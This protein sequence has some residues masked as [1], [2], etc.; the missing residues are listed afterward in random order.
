MNYNELYSNNSSSD[1]DHSD[2]GSYDDGE[3]VMCNKYHKSN[4]S[5]DDNDDSSI[6]LMIVV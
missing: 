3:D 4:D 5:N 1:D 2:S 6:R